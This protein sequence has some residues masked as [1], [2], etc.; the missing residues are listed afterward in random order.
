LLGNA[1]RMKILLLAQ[2]F[3]FSSLA[4]A[5][6][7]TI[8]SPEGNRDAAT[9]ILPDD[10]SRQASWPV[11]LLIHGYS[12]SGNS[13]NNHFGLGQ[14]VNRRGFILVLPNGRKG[15]F[16]LRYWNATDACCDFDHSRSDDVKYLT[17]LVR[18]VAGRAP[19]N[20]R[21]IYVAGHSNGAFMAHRLACDTTGLFA[22]VA[23]FAGETFSNLSDCR[24][25]E[26]ISML[27]IHAVDD[28]TIKFA[29]DEKG[30]PSLAPYPGTELTIERYL[31]RNSCMKNPE[32]R[33]N[34]D[35]I[36]TIPES[37]TEVKIW[38]SCS[39]ST[40]V[41]FWK[42]QAYRGQGHN[43]H[44]PS[45]TDEFRGALLDFLLDKARP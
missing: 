32:M 25:K 1:E 42:I 43:A 21:R 22:A 3:L 4:A 38:P 29:G 9:V 24:S 6:T 41:A 45:L 27:Q 12:G 19:V 15:K 30:F 31:E 14:E 28:G 26:P 2:F 37:D 35:L 17:D 20:P 8:P 40:Q 34:L 5:G 44:T 36:R 7:I 33:A 11:V 16:G 18:D 39:A 13:A 10:L 23:S